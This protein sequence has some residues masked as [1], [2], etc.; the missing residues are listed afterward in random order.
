MAELGARVELLYSNTTTN[1][2]ANNANIPAAVCG[3]GDHRKGRH[4]KLEDLLETAMRIVGYSAG[5]FLALD[6]ETHTL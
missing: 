6:F 4:L 5:P 2:Q 1:T 3:R